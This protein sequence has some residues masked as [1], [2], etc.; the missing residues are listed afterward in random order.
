MP[1][2]GVI[3]H[4]LLMPINQ[5]EGIQQDIPQTIAHDAHRDARRL[6]EHHGAAGARRA[7]CGPDHRAD[8]AWARAGH[9]AAEDHTARRA[10]AGAG[11]DRRRIR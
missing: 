5:L 1:I 6:R 2:R 9:D 8:G 3:P 11:A 4:N 7:A 10:G